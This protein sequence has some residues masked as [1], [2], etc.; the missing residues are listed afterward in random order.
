M[1]SSFVTFVMLIALLA[2]FVFLIRQ[3][4]GESEKDVNTEE[5]FPEI[6]GNLLEQVYRDIA[7]NI[8][9]AH[10]Q[11]VFYDPDPPPIVGGELTLMP[12]PK[13]YEP[14]K[15]K[16]I[17]EFGKASSAPPGWSFCLDRDWE[18]RILFAISR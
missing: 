8:R 4:R 17:Y 10:E 6:G 9:V 5:R 1:E 18:T 13:P 2:V 14:L 7:N 16:G 12:D 3:L 11:L 15:I